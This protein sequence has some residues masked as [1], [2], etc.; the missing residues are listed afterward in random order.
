VVVVVERIAKCGYKANRLDGFAVG[1][2][3]DNQILISIS[4][5]HSDHSFL[6]SWSL[7]CSGSFLEALFRTP[8]MD[9]FNNLEP[10]STLVVE[11]TQGS[12][13]VRCH[14]HI[15]W[16]GEEYGGGASTRAVVSSERFVIQ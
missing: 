8:G 2:Q 5:V 1:W 7:G 10:R 11:Y 9:W 3:A 13:R 6:C 4:I 15:T 14:M 12:G 16:D